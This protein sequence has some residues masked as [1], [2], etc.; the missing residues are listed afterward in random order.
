[1]D[2]L[3][4]RYLF[5]TILEAR[6]SKIKGQQIQFLMRS[7]FLACGKLITHGVLTWQRDKESFGLSS[8]YK[9]T[10]PIKTSFKSNCLP[11]SPTSKYHHIGGEDF[12]I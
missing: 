2:G 8:L 9:G 5:L 11:K 6:K 1:M 4:N 12:N 10:N 7:F 3:D